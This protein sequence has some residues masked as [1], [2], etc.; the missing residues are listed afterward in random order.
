MKPGTL[1]VDKLS[2]CTVE[3]G[4]SGDWRLL[5]MAGIPVLESALRVYVFWKRCANI[6]HE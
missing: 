6:L 2:S 5:F 3:I 4:G 1:F